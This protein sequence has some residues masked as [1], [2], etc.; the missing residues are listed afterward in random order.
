MNLYCINIRA[1]VA[2]GS[3]KGDLKARGNLFQVMV[4]SYVCSGLGCT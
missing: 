3:G 4:I 2:G 1:A